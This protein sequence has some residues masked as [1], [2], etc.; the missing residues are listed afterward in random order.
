MAVVPRPQNRIWTLQSLKWNTHFWEVLWKVFSLVL[1]KWYLRV[2]KYI[3]I[4][5]A[6]QNKDVNKISLRS[7]RFRNQ[8]YFTIGDFPE[9]RHLSGMGS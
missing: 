3:K 2:Q 5:F 7:N 6:E 4:D 8:I 1:A 9:A